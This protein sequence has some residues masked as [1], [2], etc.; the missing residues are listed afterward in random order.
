MVKSI[1]FMQS[2]QG[3]HFLRNKPEAALVKISAQ[4]RAAYPLVDD[5]IPVQVD[6]QTK[7]KWTPFL[8][9]FSG[10]TL[11]PRDSPINL[12]VD[13]PNTDRKSPR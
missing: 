2:A 5:P 1:C 3:P 8:V 7:D 6:L 10:S 11:I 12:G 9:P 13:S 4:F